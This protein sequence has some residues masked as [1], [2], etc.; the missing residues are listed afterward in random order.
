M[1]NNNQK[2]GNEKNGNGFKEYKKG[3]S[4][5]WRLALLVVMLA[6]FGVFLPPIISLWILESSKALIILSGTEWVSV[7]TMVVGLYIGGNVYQ[8]HIEKKNLSTGFSLNASVSAAGKAE[9]LEEN[10]EG[11]EA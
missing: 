4:R 7:I 10:D 1:T 2:N 9:V 3:Q 8:K 5:K 6:T 11:K